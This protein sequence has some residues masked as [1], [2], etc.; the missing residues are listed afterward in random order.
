MRPSAGIAVLA[1]LA[2]TVAAP[3]AD[4]GQST[5]ELTVGLFGVS[6]TSCK[7]CDNMLEIATGG[8]T[9]GIFSGRGG[10][11]FAAGFYVSPRA[12]IEPTLAFSHVGIGDDDLTVLGLGLAVPLYSDGSRGRRG[13]YLAPRIGYNSLDLGRGSASQFTLGLGFGVKTAINEHAAFRTQ[14]S[15]DYGFAGDLKAT[16]TIGLFLGLS[17]FV[18]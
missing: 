5:T 9:S 13:S 11:T 17:V 8:A 15:F 14:I 4:A 12:A 18:E 16:R 7:G 1:L 2:L 3:A 6:Y 10:G